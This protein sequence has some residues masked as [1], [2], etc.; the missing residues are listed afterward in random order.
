MVVEHF[1]VMLVRLKSVGEGFYLVKIWEKFVLV[2]SGRV[3]LCVIFNYNL[4][5]P[6]NIEKMPSHLYVSH[7]DR[8]TNGVGWK[9]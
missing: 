5:C 9:N 1:E 3:C 8:L 2:E 6:H 4:L 7:I